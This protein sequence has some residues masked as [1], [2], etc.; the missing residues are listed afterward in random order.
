MEDNSKRKKVY[1]HLKIGQ[2]NL[3]TG[4]VCTSEIRKISDELGIDILLM[5]EPYTYKKV[6][7][8]TWTIP[9]MGMTSRVTPS[10][11]RDPFFASVV[12]FNEQ[13]DYLSLEGYT[14][15]YVAAAE[16]KTRNQSLVLVSAYFPPNDNLSESIKLV[17][18]IIKDFK[19]HKVI[20]GMDSNSKSET[21]FSEY[22][23]A[24]GREL[25]DFISAYN[26]IAF[27]RPDL[28]QQGQSVFH[29]RV[30]MLLACPGG[31]GDFA[32]GKHASIMSTLLVA[33]YDKQGCCGSTLLPPPR[34]GCRRRKKPHHT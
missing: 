32:P 28:T 14:S 34:R 2:I 26:L 9:G 22:T 33:S 7:N 27:P 4:K 31:G 20:L 3:G 30:P 5:Q 8:N 15:R 17:E 1:E 16:I 12:C 24:R 10:H 25:E 18:N 11:S 23:D 19:Y 29:V 6:I 21:W 13:F